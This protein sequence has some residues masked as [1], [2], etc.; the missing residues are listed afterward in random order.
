VPALRRAPGA[1]NLS[2]VL[3]QQDRARRRGPPVR[4]ERA[5]FESASV[6]VRVASTEGEC[7]VSV[8]T[9]VTIRLVAV[10]QLGR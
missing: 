2:A 4:A 3:G 1:R 5:G 8:E 7:P 6:L 10:T 9:P